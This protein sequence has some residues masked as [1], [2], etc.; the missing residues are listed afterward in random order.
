MPPYDGTLSKYYIT[1]SDFRY[2]LPPHLDLISGA[3]V[4]P[5]AVAVSALR[6]ANL[7]SVHRAHSPCVWLWTDRTAHSIGRASLR[8]ITRRG[9]R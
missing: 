2:K 4:E 3:L 9:R 5:V 8:R 6:T 7:H 1:A